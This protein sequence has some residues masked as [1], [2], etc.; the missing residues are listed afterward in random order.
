MSD[1]GGC[2]N[3]MFEVSRAKLLILIQSYVTMQG[4]SP[5]ENFELKITA[6]KEL[7]FD[8]VFDWVSLE[9]VPSTPHMNLHM[10]FTGAVFT[11]TGQS[12]VALQDGEVIA[13][14]DAQV[15]APLSISAVS[16]ELHVTNTTLSTDFLGDANKILSGMFD[17]SS[18]DMFPDTDSTVADI[19][20]SGLTGVGG[21]VAYCLDA[22]TIAILD[23]GGSASKKTK[24]LT[25]GHDVALGLSADFVRSKGICPDLITDIR[26][27]IMERR[28]LEQSSFNLTESQIDDIIANPK[29]HP[30]EDAYA[31]Q[32]INNVQSNPLAAFISHEFKDLIP[33]PCG[34]GTLTLST[35]PPVNAWVDNL[36]FTFEN[37]YIQVDATFKAHA[38]CFSIEDGTLQEKVYLSVSGQ[39]VTGYYLPK[40]PSPQ[41]TIDMEWWCA[42]AAGLLAPVFKAITQS[43]LDG[44]ISGFMNKETLPT[45]GGVIPTPGDV[46]WDSLK[47][48]T[49]GIM[50]E[51]TSSVTVY[52]NP[53]ESKIWFDEKDTALNVQD[54]G[55]GVYHFPGTIACKA[56][57]FTYEHYQQ[58]ESIELLAKS[59]ML[60]EPVSYEWVLEGQT[61][62]GSGVAEFTT[63]VQEALPPPNGTWLSPQEVEVS[64]GEG[65]SF[66]YK[67]KGINQTA[68]MVLGTRAHDLN[69]SAT[70]QLQATDATGRKFSYLGTV[71]VVGDVAQFGQDYYDFMSKCEIATIITLSKI[72]YRPQRFINDGRG[73]TNEKVVSIIKEALATGDP[74]A[75]TMLKVFTAS[76]GAAALAPVFSTRTGGAPSGTSVVIKR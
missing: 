34:E 28:V 36:T 64:Y 70:M 50:F 35:T 54:L 59:T 60:I 57:D 63:P 55:S 8:G 49:E 71:H 73:V 27:D 37:G 25:T 53:V 9:F 38:P 22:D 29:S 10:H 20:S 23:S 6:N 51:G 42:L 40:T 30:T 14:F 18:W 69:Y 4:V 16:A 76:R 5:I 66:I 75:G 39:K 74:T 68:R 15:G 52:A 56:Q 46:S 32:Q 45:I 26:D 47:I 33:P 12:P 65:W 7:Q 11:L 31:K 1:L 48:T 17:S 3:M 41:Y 58:D 44:I 72:R 24:T 21:G 13:H 67:W 2:N 62:K 43:I 19:V 61:I